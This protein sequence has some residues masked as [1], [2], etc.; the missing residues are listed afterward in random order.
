MELQSLNEAD[1]QKDGDACRDSILTGYFVL[2]AGNTGCHRER[3]EDK[4]VMGE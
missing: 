4:K 1:A 2:G 3:E